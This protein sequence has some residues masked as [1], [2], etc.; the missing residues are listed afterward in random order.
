MPCS[1]YVATGSLFSTIFIT[2]LSLLFISN[3][4]NGIRT[5]QSYLRIAEEI[6]ES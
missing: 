6:A 3:T 4:C 5:R 2:S 1:Y